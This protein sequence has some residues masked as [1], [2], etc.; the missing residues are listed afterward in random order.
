M[1]PL[2]PL[3]VVVP[4]EAL[5]T[6]VALERAVLLRVVLGVRMVVVGVCC[7]QMLKGVLGVLRIL[8]PTASMMHHRYA[9]HGRKLVRRSILRLRLNGN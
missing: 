6:N 1:Y 9:A 8:L 7:G 2:V 3:Q 4:A 5:R